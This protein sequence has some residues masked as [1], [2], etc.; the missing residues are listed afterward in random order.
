MTT[1]QVRAYIVKRQEKGASNASINRELSTL[2][3][4]LSLGHKQTPPKVQ[5]MPYIPKL[6]ENNVRTGYFEHHEYLAFRDTLPPYIRPIF[7]TGY[8]T[9]MRL[10]EILSLQWDQVNM[11][12]GKITLKAGNQND[13]ARVIFLKR[14]TPRGHQDT[15]YP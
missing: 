10:G 11:I 12:E 14:G 15:A 9:G 3:R 1:D 7:I 2:K 13:E 8:H 6:K 5:Y 4:M